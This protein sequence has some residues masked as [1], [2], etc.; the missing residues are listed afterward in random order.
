MLLVFA[1][2]IY[3]LWLIS[4]EDLK[5]LFIISNN[6]FAPLKNNFLKI[7]LLITNLQSIY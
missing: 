5:I 1:I 6:F 3:Q 2:I 7:I 4:R